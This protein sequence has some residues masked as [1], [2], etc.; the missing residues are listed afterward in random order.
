MGVGY[1]DETLEPIGGQEVLLE[2]LLV[3]GNGS[4][5]YDVS[6]SGTL[7]YDAA[8]GVDSENQL[9]EVAMDG[10]STA[11]SEAGGS[12]W[13]PKYSPDGTRIVYEEMRDGE[14]NARILDLA[15][16]ADR[17]FTTSGGSIP[18]WSSDG[19]Y[20]YFTK[21]GGAS[22]QRAGYRRPA[23][24][25]E[26]ETRLFSMEGGSFWFMDVSDDGGFAIISQGL[27]PGGD[28]HLARQSGDTMV[29]EPLLDSEDGE[30]LADISPDGR[31]FVYTSDENGENRVYANSFPE[32]TGRRPVSPGH[33]LD[34]VWGPEGRRIF[35]RSG[36]RFYVVDVTTE[37]GTFT[38]S[39]PRMLFDRADFVSRGGDLFR[40]WDLNP[41]GDRFV[42]MATPGGTESFA[43]EMYVVTN[44]FEEL[45][46]KMGN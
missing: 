46:E 26:A 9:V 13:L 23:D 11:L 5:Q 18:V 20:L 27:G 24:S 25:R 39:A 12:I 10:T 16:G 42:M 41:D 31:W 44:W 38:P 21:A 2:R 28:L 17:P 35:Y 6:S 40:N 29:V 37:D 1:D 7:F 22:N 3:H 19:D 33:G 32:L 14:T 43:T 45:L 36:G 30:G 4:A 8:E 34:P 15:L